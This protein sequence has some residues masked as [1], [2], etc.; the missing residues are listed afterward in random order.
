MATFRKFR[1]RWQ[2]QVRQRG[3]GQITKTFGSKAEALSWGRQM[4]ADIGQSVR[5]PDQGKLDEV[6]FGDLLER[7]QR[8]ILPLKRAGEKERQLLKP[9]M[10][11]PFCRLSLGRLTPSDFISYRDRRLGSVKPASVC[12]VLAILQHA[13]EVARLDWNIPLAS[14]PLKSVRRPRIIGGRDRRLMPEEMER[15]NVALAGCRAPTLRELVALALETGMRRG[16]LLSLDWSHV[17]LGVRVAH[18]PITKNGFSRDVPLS[19]RAI[20]VLRS[21]G[22]NDEGLVF[23]LSP[24]AVRLAWQRVRLRAGIPD[25]RFHDLR[26]EAV[27]RFFEKGLEMME[28]ATISGHRDLRMLR[29][30][31][32]LKAAN[33]ALKPG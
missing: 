19:T 33:L 5:L 23:P 27:S 31:T 13:L 30:Y 6:T 32:H 18:L 28:V 10:T 11:E 1:D 21:L 12:R 25:T 26:H 20:E 7:Y 22:P 16:E 4:E 8:E 3:I 15:P 2:A 9:V 29:H 24:N 17:D 14:N